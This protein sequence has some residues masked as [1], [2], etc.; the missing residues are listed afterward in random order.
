M[1]KQFVAGS[2]KGMV[3]G[4]AFPSFWSDLWL[5]AL[6][7]ILTCAVNGLWDPRLVPSCSSQQVDAVFVSLR[8]V[9]GAF[10]DASK[11]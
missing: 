9:K 2:S 11:I 1:E 6:R 7:I 8:E 5:S 3:A 10:I 4:G